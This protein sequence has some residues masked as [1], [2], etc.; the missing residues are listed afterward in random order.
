[1]YTIRFTDSE[2]ETWLAHDVTVNDEAT[3]IVI[4]DVGFQ[5]I[6]NGFGVAT[7]V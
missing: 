1:M 5:F 2:E 7:L 3:S 6:R 4:G